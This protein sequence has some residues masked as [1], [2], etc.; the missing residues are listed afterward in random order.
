MKKLF[1]LLFV[2]L[3]ATSAWA[4]TD[5]T[6][7]FSDQG[8]ANQAVVESLTVGDVTVAFAQ[9]S[10]QN[11]A[12]TYYTNG[13][14][15]RIYVGNTMT[16]STAGT[17]PITKIVFTYA[18][19]TGNDWTSACVTDGAY[20]NGIW[21]GSAT[22]ILFTN[23]K[24][25]QV[26][27]VSMVVT[28]GGEVVEVID[29]PTLPAAQEFED[30]FTVNITNNAA[31]ATVKYSTDSVTWLD[32][33][34]PF[35]ITETTTVYAK[36][37]KGNNES[38]VVSAKYTKL[39]VEEGS[40]IFLPNDFPVVTNAA[41]SS[42]KNHVTVAGTS[43]TITTDQI[44]MFKNSTTTI[45]TTVG[46]IVK[47][48]FTCT[49]SGT[50]QYGPGCFAAQTG[51]SYEGKIGTW[52]G[53]ATSVEF[54]AETNQVR[55]TQIVV[56]IEGNDPTV[57]VVAPVF[58]PGSCTFTGSQVINLTC[59]TEGAQIL[60]AIDEGA[61]Q[62]YTAP[63]TITQACTIKA[64]ATLNGQESSEVTATYK[65]RTEVSTIAAANALD[66]KTDF[67]FYGPA[68][69][70]YQNGSNLWIKDNTGCGLIYGNQVPTIAEGATLAE[71]WEAQT[72]LYHTMIHEFRY[73]NY[74]EADPDEPIQTIT[75]TEYT[76]DALTTD[77]INERVII[78]GLTLVEETDTEVENY[79]RY[80]YNIVEGD[81]L[82]LYKFTDVT[83]PTVEE[84][85]TYDVEAMVSYFGNK[86]QLLP[87]AI[88][89]SQAAPAGLRGDVNGDQTVSI[90][91]VTALIDYL[92]SHDASTIS[93]ENA[94]CNLD[95]NISIADVT[96]LIDYLLS[97]H[98]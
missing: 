22:S 93:L 92:L 6:I 59:E 83:Y 98:W 16:V 54:V 3:L 11:T 37:V 91:D 60:Y 13:T 71:G 88:T 84:G 69:V 44:R 68:V 52:E 40:V 21:A 96:A 26:R 74:V 62:N 95:E 86:V 12:P 48:E 8:Y 2:A 97:K 43:G 73:P 5:V 31:D 49:A 87:I 56:W 4:A 45:S 36:A 50:S 23:V 57:Q 7:D 78:K 53:E 1:S 79:A 28:L 20:D 30:S 90:A 85:K 80:L 51:Y 75:A 55:A 27:I 18:T 9:G 65:K 42:T 70:T 47:I 39:E 63:F 41:F 81:T 25:N 89:E 46:K 24:S 34:A 67:V 58:D 77:N 15:I 72:Y 33:T 35:T 38:S 14:A 76:R 64:K 82:V 61:Y 29:A 94:D 32:Y 17:D 66:N 19:G 10:H